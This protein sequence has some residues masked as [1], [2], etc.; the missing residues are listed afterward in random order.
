MNAYVYQSPAWPDLTWDAE[1]VAPLLARVHFLRGRLLGQIKMLGF[2]QQ[3]EALLI[4]LTQETRQSSAIEGE[5]L[6]A[7]QIRSS[8][9]R[10]LGI[11][12][13]G[14]PL[15]SREVEGVVDM[16]LDATQR[17]DQPLTKAR[18]CGWQTG[19]FPNGWSG[20]SRVAI[21][22]WRTEEMRV[23]SGRTGHERVH[24]TAPAPKDVPG[25]MTRFLKWFNADTRTD[26]VLK[27]A[28]AHFKFIIIHPFDDGNGRV[29]RAI[30]ELQLA[31]ADGIK[32]RFYSLSGQMMAERKMYY[33]TLERTQHASGDITEWMVWFSGCFSRTLETAGATLS[34]INHKMEF[35]SRHEQ[36][37]FNARQRIVLNRLLDGFEGKLTSTKWATLAKC[38]P[39]TALRDIAELVSMSMLQK[40]SS[41]GRNTHYGL[42][43]DHD[44]MDGGFV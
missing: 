5:M 2:S 3:S 31:R 7:A 26:A 32:E 44:V 30:S 4:A 14:L 20:L 29:A 10:R 17:F 23:V 11:N 35:W 27:A 22:A 37:A 33:Q 18:L 15:P 19:L 21:G 9:A 12:T 24:Y 38:S 1:T 13:A 8:I 25:E 34:R 42:T 6:D 41:G 43:D 28:L 16:M 36:T 39:D 40:S